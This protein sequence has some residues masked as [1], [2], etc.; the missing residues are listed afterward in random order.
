MRLATD[1]VDFAVER[2]APVVVKLSDVNIK[3]Q[4]T[5][6]TYIS[7][8]RGVLAAHLTRIRKRAHER[9]QFPAT[10]RRIDTTFWI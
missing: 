7:H 3:K 4:V 6:L 10:T 9:N 5:M 8:A 1:D 2:V